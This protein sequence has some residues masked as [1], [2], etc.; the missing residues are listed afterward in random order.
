MAVSGSCALALGFA[1][2]LGP[3]WMGAV[4][5][6]WG[7]TIV[8]DSAQFSASI[9]E[10]AEPTLVGTMLTIQASAGFLLTLITIHLMPVL[11]EYL[12]WTYAFAGLAIGPFL[13][14][15]AMARL[16]RRPDS[17]KLAQGRR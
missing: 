12:G 5:L 8:S 4:A 16:R 7:L 2:D 14:V 15:L 3:W 10:L 1:T 17:I 13:G 6:V 11:V 9:A